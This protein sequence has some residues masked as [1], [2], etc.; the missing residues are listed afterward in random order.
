MTTGKIILIDGTSSSGKTS[1]VHAL[2]ERL[3]EPYLESGL[4]KFIWMM[5]KHYLDRP[6]WED[7]FGLADKAGEAGQILVHGM[8]QSIA[9]LSKAGVNVLADHVLIEIAWVQ[10]CVELFAD[11]PAYLL[12]VQCPLDVLEQREAARKNRTLGQAKLQFPIIH[13]YVLYDLEVDTSKSTPEECAQSIIL[14]MQ[15][16]PDALKRLKSRMI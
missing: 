12:G 5:P 16:P 1:I 10:E 4:D 11:S 3:D 8:H 9:A 6:L 7:V 15:N 13:T 14:R 2:Q